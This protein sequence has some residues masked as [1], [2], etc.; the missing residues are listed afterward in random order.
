MIVTAVTPTVI[1]VYFR[2]KQTGRQCF[3]EDLCV[4]NKKEDA[5]AFIQ[6]LCTHHIDAEGIE[7]NSNVPGGQHDA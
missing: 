1:S 4:R 7:Q 3:L 2:V 6:T 5:E